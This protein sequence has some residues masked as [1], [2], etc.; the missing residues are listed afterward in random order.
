VAIEL[1]GLRMNAV[2]T[3]P[4]GVIDR[5]TIFMFHQDGDRV[6]AEYAGGRIERGYLV[7]RLSGTALE[8]R[9]CQRE[10]NGTLG[11]GASTC[12]VERDEESRVRIVE[13]FTW[14][15]RPGGGQNVLRE[16]R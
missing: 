1:D 14:E 3:D 6:H 2:E 15:S 16:L 12:E 10:A 5:D 11:S 8:F 4:N 7:G 13:N 9:Y